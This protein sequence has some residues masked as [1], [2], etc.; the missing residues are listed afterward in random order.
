VDEI[1]RTESPFQQE[2]LDDDT[3]SETSE[4]SLEEYDSSLIKGLAALSTIKQDD[5]MDV[6][7]V[8]SIRSLYISDLSGYKH[9]IANQMAAVSLHSLLSSYFSLN[10][11][12]SLVNY[13]KVSAW[14]KFINKV[15]PIKIVKS[16]IF[17]LLII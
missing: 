7:G 4:S 10:Q 11:L 13:Q 12:M 8:S 1:E 9:M 15:V 3:L 16:N 17:I 2:R 14:S 5:N 6:T